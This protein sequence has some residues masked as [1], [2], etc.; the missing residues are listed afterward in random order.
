MS[1]SVLSCYLNTTDYYSENL[2]DLI[3]IFEISVED[4][5]FFIFNPG[6][7]LDLIPIFYRT[8]LRVK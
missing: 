1:S 2:T 3:V 4:F 6:F 7:N 8:K 5:H